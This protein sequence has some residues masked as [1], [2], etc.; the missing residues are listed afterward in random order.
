MK[1]SLF[2]IACFYS[3]LVSGQEPDAVTYNIYE[4]NLC[5]GDQLKL[6]SSS[7]KF[8]K[9]ISDSRCPQGNAV[10]CIW[11]GEVKV[12]VEIFE[13]GKLKGEE[14]IVGSGGSINGSF[15][16]EGIDIQ[17]FTVTPYPKVNR[18][19]LPEEYTLELKISEEVETD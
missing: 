4:A 5:S 3:I 14:F 13:N 10:T 6:G 18:K 7:V 2:L 15:L 9:V 1:I 8:I 12:L 11:A 17:G 19:I 16:E